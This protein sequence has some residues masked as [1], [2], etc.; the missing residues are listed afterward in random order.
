MLMVIGTSFSMEYLLKGIYENAIGRLSEWS[1]GYQAVDEDRYADEVAREYADFVHIRPFYEFRFARHVGGL[2]SRT[3]FW[4]AHLPRKW[5]RKAFLTVDYTAESFYCWLIEKAT[6][7]TYGEEPVSTYAWI[8]N[9]DSAL[10]PELPRMKMVKQTGPREFIV[11]IPRYQEFTATALVLAE[12]RVRFVEIAGNSRII[13][14]VLAPQSWHYGDSQAPEL[15]STPVL[16][17]PGMKRAV[18]GCEAGWLNAV[19]Q[20][21]RAEGVS[22]E[23]VYDY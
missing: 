3:S 17:H 6:H 21:L 4:G 13:V 9:A 2:W 8:S 10:W 19:V 11:D 14:S 12:R 5:E 1:S 18:I 7:W 15:F 23:H 16:T 22:V 20:E